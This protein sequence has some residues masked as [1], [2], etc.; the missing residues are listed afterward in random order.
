MSGLT[1]DA[2]G[3][4]AALCSMTSF[5]PQVTKILREH[6]VSGVSFRMYLVTVT[7]FA[8]WTSY[9]VLLGHWPLI[10]ANAVSLVL[11]ACV[12]GLKAWFSWVR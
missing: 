12:L 9:G 5:V 6:D 1:A 8:L 3:A 4:A 11:S 10:V 7:G 2:V